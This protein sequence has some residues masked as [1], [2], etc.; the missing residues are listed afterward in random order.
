MDIADKNFEID[1]IDRKIINILQKDASFSH[2]TIG[3]K[4][5]LS[6]SSVNERIRKLKTHHVIKKIVAIVDPQQIGADVFAYIMVS[7]TG[8]E[9]ELQFGK[10]M[11]AFEEILECHHVTGEYS[12]LLKVRAK[13]MAAL[14]SLLINKIN[15]LSGFN[16]SF[17]QVVL[18]S[19]KE[20]T[21]ITC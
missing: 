12:Y 20:E 19:F 14:E 4:V 17:T 11:L 5:G 8:P 13:N 16:R 6:A 1:L 18:S 10:V 15:V 21:A 9:N 3:E 2:A 7:I